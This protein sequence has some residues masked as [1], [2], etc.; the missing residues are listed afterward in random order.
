[1]SASDPQTV[2]ELKWTRNIGIMAHID[3]GKT[4]TTERIL[5]YTGKNYK[6]GEVHDGAATMDW[7]EQE[8]ERGIT[9][10][11]AATTCAWNGHRINIIDTPGHVDFTIEVERSLRVLDGAVAV[12]DVVNGVEPQSETVWR[13][14]DKYRVPRICFLNKMDRIGA[15]FEGS[16]QSLVEKLGANPVVIQLPI[17][18]EDQ[19]RGVVDLI[20]NKAIEWTGEELGAKF[21][22]KEIPGDLKAI[23]ETWRSQMIEKIV[24][25]DDGLMDK[26]L[27]GKDISADELRGA[28]RKGTL[29]LQ[30]FPVV[31]GAAFRNRGVQPLLDAVVNFLPSPIDVPPVE[32][33]SPFTKEIVT[34]P[35]E[36]DAPALA[37]AFKIATDP[38]VGSLT[39]L[40]VY[41]GTIKTGTA[42]QNTAREKKEKI[43]RLVKMH[44]NTREEVS[45]LKAGDIGA[46]AGLKF[47][48][49]GDT[50]CDPA[51]QIQLE[52]ITF[53]E[54]VISMA[55]EAKS[56]AEQDRMNEVL[57]KMEQE[58]PSFRR[59]SDPETG[60][61]LICGMGELHLDIIV[62]RLK[63]EFKVEVNL[64]SPQVSYK[65]TITQRATAENRYERQI[66]G[67]NVFGHC[68]LEVEPKDRGTGFEFVNRLKKDQIPAAFIG[69]IEQGAREAMETG[70]LA[71]YQMVDVKVTLVNATFHETDSNEL[72]FKIS[73]SMAFRQAAQQAQ[74]I[75]LEPISKLEVL[76]PEEFMG[77]V[78]G[79]LNGRRGK[80]SNMTARG[81]TQ[82]VHA[83]V[84]LAS[85]F[86]YATQLRSITQGRATFTMSPSHY[87]P[88]PPKQQDEILV[89]LGRK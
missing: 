39:Y 18:V 7:M 22:V 35:T 61:M 30:A 27:E 72:A 26:Y 52:A 51:R 74:P 40:R 78:I 1:M 54:P 15:D 32:G 84:P 88:V 44:A 53:P 19:F 48:I 60:Q 85:M 81:K 59:R 4:T 62:D 16:V 47:T 82:I 46:A 42:L 23:A 6:M 87:A 75:L 33:Y 50:L 24:E 13:Q 79:D 14:A 68:V 57:A 76:T 45:F 77:T 17:G 58:D 70:A 3:A 8:Q 5:F 34:C 41:S 49:T 36:F 71:G 67:K 12:F 10:T 80:V 21:A 29:S 69:P 65:E 37:L 38:F 31:C 9:I 83:E 89:R 56:T 11:A 20:E 66:G 28:L 55:I 2:D 63:R 25:F 73:A 64:G 86:G 43:Q